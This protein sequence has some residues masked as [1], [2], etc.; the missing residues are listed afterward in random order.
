MNNSYKKFF[1]ENYKFT[2]I[3][4]FILT[5][6]CMIWEPWASLFFLGVLGV[7]FLGSYNSWKNKKW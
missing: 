7:L 3:F 2:F 4:I 6:L 5:T 1:F